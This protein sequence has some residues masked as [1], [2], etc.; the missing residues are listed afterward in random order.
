MDSTAQA[1]SGEAP[2]PLASGDAPSQAQVEELTAEGKE[3][4]RAKTQE[5]QERAKRYL[6]Q[7]MPQDRR[8]QAIW[9]LK[10]SRLGAR[11]VGYTHYARR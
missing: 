5:Y 11:S 4:A 2:L 8:E 1:S 3:A 6:Q 9:R 10:V 7:K